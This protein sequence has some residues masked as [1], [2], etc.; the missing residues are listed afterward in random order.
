MK[1]LT[2]ALLIISVYVMC[3]CQ[4]KEKPNFV[5]ITLDTFRAD[6]LEVYGDKK[7]LAPNL[8]KF[9]KEA[10]VFTNAITPTPVTLPAHAII[11]TGCFQ[12]KTTLL[13]NGVGILS[14]KVKTIAE[15]LKDKGYETR[16]YVAAE[17][18]KAKYGL[19]RGFTIYD[20]NLGYTG[21]RFATEI[22]ELAISFLSGKMEKPFFLW[23]HY[24]DTHQPYLTPETPAGEVQ[25]DYDRAVSYLDKELKRVFDVIPPNTYVF[26]VSDHGEG[27]KEHGE[28]T[29]GI[30]LYQPTMKVVMMVKGKGF[31]AETVSKFKSL[32]DIAP[33]I[34]QI[35]GE[36][37]DD[38]DGLT[39]K[40]DK[41][42]VVP[43][44]TL[45]PLNEFRWKPL[46]GVTDGKYKWI[47]GEELK[48]FDLI[49]DPDEA[50]NIAKIAPEESL[51]L[52]SKIFS[53]EAIRNTMELS[54]FSGLGYLTGTPTKETMIEDL[55]DPEKMISVFYQIDRIR[56]LREKGNY[57]EAAKIAEEALKSDKGN[58]SLL[59]SY[60][61]SL[62][63]IGNLDDAIKYLDESLKISPT[64]VPSYVSKGYALI[65]RE[66]KD[67]AAKCF[68]KALEYDPDSIEALNPLIGYYLDLNKP[69]V[70]LPMLEEAIN[71]GIATADT[72]LMQG[73]VH[74]IQNKQELAENDFN[75]ALKVTLRPEETLKSIGDIYL[76]RGYTGKARAIFLEGI[77][78]YPDFYPN[79]LT[80]GAFYITYEDYKS[81]LNIFEKALRLDLPPQERKNVS[82]IVE[83]LKKTLNVRQD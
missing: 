72:Y 6:R 23:L 73:R 62:R 80:L 32:A 33:T 55:P 9:S 12:N 69:Q 58:P 31:K 11:F 49:G 22:S 81:A 37:V 68:E 27:L 7:N 48:L 57:L 61:D 42:K 52:K 60:G 50:V 24:F 78:R 59:F 63:H 13:D 41:K 65:A 3:L 2:F 16:A 18:L 53:Y 14:P 20:D 79:Y 75:N 82:E 64:L 8:N 56:I 45:L 26:I 19:S 34:Y 44:L 25:G 35:V 38:V 30:L 21:R 4:E 77:K 76:M 46:F 51:Y 17:V 71:K 83:G 40:E 10:T 15:V 54:S 5:I 39:L 66:R 67:E 74:L 70:A 28:L 36:R 29:H 47:K 1:K 43:L